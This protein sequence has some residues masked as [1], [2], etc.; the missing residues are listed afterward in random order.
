MYLDPIARHSNPLIEISMLHVP[1]AIIR[2]R[3]LGTADRLGG[4]GGMRPEHLTEHRTEH[5]TERG[6]RRPFGRWIGKTA[7]VLMTAGMALASPGAGFG[8]QTQGGEGS[9]QGQGSLLPEIDP[10][11]IEIRSQY[12]ARFPGVTRQ[13]ILGFN[14][15][16]RV[17]RVDPDRLPY[18]ETQ[19]EVVV[20][21]PLGTLSR[22]VPPG[23]E[24]LPRPA[25]RSGRIHA[26]MGT[27]Q[28]PAAGARLS[29]PMGRTDKSTA[30]R[31]DSTGLTWFNLSL[32]AQSLQDY[33][34]NPDGTVR[35]GRM[36][37]SFVRPSDIRNGFETRLDA[38]HTENGMLIPDF[39]TN[40]GLGPTFDPA[41]GAGAP[42]HRSYGIEIATSLRGPEQSF[43][44]WRTDLQLRGARYE[45][46]GSPTALE[47]RSEAISAEVRQTKSW[48]GT[49]PLDVFTGD[50][51]AGYRMVG[52][53]EGGFE[54]SRTAWLTGGITLERIVQDRIPASTRLSA[55][56]LQY[57]NGVTL[58]PGLETAF[59]LPLPGRLS[60]HS[61]LRAEADP[62]SI[63]YAMRRNPYLRPDADF[64][65]TYGASVFSE[66]LY[67][68]QR[69]G[70]VRS[71]ARYQLAHNYLGFERNQLPAA[72]G[73]LQADYFTTT[74]LRASILELY[75]SVTQPFFGERVGF[76]F[77]G[78][79][80]TPTLL[81]GGRIPYEESLGASG[82]LSVRPHR[83][84]R[85]TVTS[86]FVG[87]RKTSSG[88]ELDPY[89]VFSAEL[90][91]LSKGGFGAYVR[92]VNLLNTTYSIWDGVPERPFE[93]F[94][95]FTFDF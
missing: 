90:R 48:L 22:P 40:P 46:S 72:D 2:K 61:A 24:P 11:D 26:G 19:E 13:P 30:V 71:G 7:L 6:G 78:W 77:E 54:E 8:Q 4:P 27:L 52:P 15:R 91:F 56:L 95:G 16:P 33:E 43:E 3:H 53:A 39:V 34:A 79:Y 31:T 66:L 60:F 68:L 29:I 74:H 58:L 25:L 36:S 38:F 1:S 35:Q 44:T 75:G 59:T 47:A 65:H 64:R 9:G 57:Q 12:R 17:Y 28:S 73:T 82:T 42:L 87:S 84:L 62:F 93:V 45:L 41:P 10:Q 86:D 83:T 76:S 20:N 80:R 37:M 55:T 50:L 32:D 49:R 23:Y 88:D 5:L 85:L 92:G 67:T 18:M 14:P 70:E 89:T 51:S 21:L 69:G 63:E 81:E 94:G